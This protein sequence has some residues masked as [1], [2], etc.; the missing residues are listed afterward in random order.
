MEKLEIVAQENSPYILLD[1]ENLK[2][3]IVGQSLPENVFNI[4]TPVLEW[5]KTNLVKVNGKI[6]FKFDV[7]YFNSSSA[8]MFAEI[9]NILES[10]KQSG[11]EIEIHWFFE[12]DDVDMEEEGKHYQ[13]NSTVPFVLIEK[14]EED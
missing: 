10:L 12:M 11:K 7:F 4:Y 6:I 1:G 3:E 9:I 8:K 14:E 13:K 5:L 2:F